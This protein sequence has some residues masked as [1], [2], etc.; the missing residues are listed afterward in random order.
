M[1]LEQCFYAASDVAQYLLGKQFDIA[2]SVF[3]NGYTGDI[4]NSQV[5]VSEKLKSTA[6]GTTTGVFSDG[7]TITIGGTVIT[8]KAALGATAGQVL[9]GANAAASLTNITAAINGSA[10]AGST[11]NDIVEECLCFGFIDSQPRKVSET[12]A[13]IYISPRKRGSEWSKL[14]KSRIVMLQKKKLMQPAG[15]KVIA[16]AKKD[17]SWNKIDSSENF[18]EPADFQ[19]A[20][21]KNK[22]HRAH[23][24]NLAPSTRKAFLHRLNSAKTSE[25]REKRLVFL[26]Q[27]L[28]VEMQVVRIGELAEMAQVRLDQQF[29]AAAPDLSQLF[30]DARH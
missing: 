27:L 9:I 19:A 5:Y 14:N 11:Y 29:R 2:E 22:R 3:K 17:G 12:Q 10:G 1:F 20:L 7:E 24:D 8:M 28:E 25:T 16:A 18:E 6:V 26:I 13:S 30:V 23:F 4:S 21:K 15:L